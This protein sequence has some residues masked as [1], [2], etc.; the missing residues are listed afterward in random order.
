MGIAVAEQAARRGADVTLVAANVSLPSPPG[1]RRVDVETAAELAD[2]LD[3][4]FGSADV[5][6][7]SAAPADFRPREAAGEKIH[8]EGADRLELD[9]EPTEDI[10]ASLGKRRREGQTI[11][12]FA[13]ETPVRSTGPARS[14][15][16]RAP[17]Q[18][19]STTSPAPR[20]ASS[21]TRTRW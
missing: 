18:S 1:I 10:L 12:G 15:T 14:S 2:A 6:M 8:R 4:E 20:S 9:L 7:M 13:A 21:R 17:T 11:V 19:S 5:L 16:A 3:S